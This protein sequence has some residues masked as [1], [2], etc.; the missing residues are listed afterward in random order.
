MAK[1]IENET[2][3]NSAPSSVAAVFGNVA[4]Q[5]YGTSVVI[6][7]NGNVIVN[8]K[9]IVHANGNVEQTVSND[10]SVAAAPKT[11]EVGERLED[12]TVCIDVDLKNNKALFAPEGIFGGAAKFD[13]QDDVVEKVNAGDGLHGHKDWCRITDAEGKK[14]SDVWNK[15]APPA[16]Q[17]SA[18]PWFWLA[19]PGTNGRMRRG[20][21]ADGTYGR[22][23]LRPVPVV[24]SGP[25]LS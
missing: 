21:E 16:L 8:N 23:C 5:G 13:D 11:H 17:G 4:V 22:D 15:V 6:Q 10:S 18:A 24:R 9:V 25:A 3:A 7:P 20:G 19:S 1:A 2:P 12:G 14:L